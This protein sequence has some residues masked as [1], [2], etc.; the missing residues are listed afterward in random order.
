MDDDAVM[1]AL[2]RTAFTVTAH[3]SQVAAAHDLSLT[4]M[5]VLGIL[6]DREPRLAELAAHLGLERSSVSGLVDR[7]VRRGLVRRE[8]S[9]DDG[10]AVRLSL[11]EQGQALAARGGA[12]MGELL[13]PMM[14][15]LNAGERQRFGV[16]LQRLLA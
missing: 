14:A 11:T 6:R 7:A 5:R 8:A 4:Q 3:L 16:L 13:A 1:D 12:E 10:R 2:V 15:K 9:A